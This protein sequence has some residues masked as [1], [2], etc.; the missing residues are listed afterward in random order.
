MG[1]SVRKT[2]CAGR[3]H[4]E[5]VKF[6]YQKWME[7]QAQSLIDATTAAFKAGKLPGGMPPGGP[8]GVAIPP[9]IG[10]R[11]PPGMIPPPGMPG[12]PPHMMG[13]PRPGMMPMRPGHPGMVPP[14]GAGMPGPPGA[15]MG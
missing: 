12:M 6:Y 7:E 10:M 13:P 5:N 2:H 1:P 14:P 15:G 9:P 3:K 4:K 11:P 8:G